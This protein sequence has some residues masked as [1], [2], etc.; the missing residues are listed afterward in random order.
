MLAGLAAAVLAVPSPARAAN[1]AHVRT[2]VLWPSECARVVDRSVDPIAHFDY[3]IAAEDTDKTA[4][5]L[6][7]SRTHQFV[8]LCRQHPMTELL[9]PW[10]TRDDVDRSV[11]AGLLE[12]GEVSYREILDETTVWEACFARITADDDR[13]P[14]TFAAAEAGFDWDTSA[15]AAGVWSIAGYTFEPSFNLWRDRPGFVKILDDPDDPD[16]DLPALALLADEQL[17]DVGQAIVLDACVDVLTPARIELEW[18][19]FAASL[20][21]QPLASVELDDDG[22]L[23]LEPLAPAA[24]AD[25]E[26]LV[27]A[28]L[29]DALGREY[30]SHAPTRMTILPCPASGCPPPPTPETSDDA[31][32]RACAV[33]VG[34]DNGTRRAGLLC[35]LLMLCTARART[36]ARSQ[37]D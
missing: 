28:R 2:P 35:L 11:D 36:A 7:D 1:E 10:I 19:P 14:I 16:Q 8:A 3:S 21:W 4:D 20:D 29:I 32:T 9:P 33:V 5:E 37:L 17:V 6:P 15:V 13:R 31:G 22:P 24:A 27:R 23:L 12:P 25:T 26:V 34:P 18:A 30:E